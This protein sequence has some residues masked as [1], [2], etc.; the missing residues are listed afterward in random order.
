MPKGILKDIKRPP[1]FWQR[2]AGGAIS[3]R[4]LKGGPPPLTPEA[5]N[6]YYGALVGKAPQVALARVAQALLWAD[7][8]ARQFHSH[9]AAWYSWRWTFSPTM[10]GVCSML[11]HST[12][13]A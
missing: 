6:Y 2:L 7:I 10:S 1:T 3:A 4:K 5:V 11:P 9:C 13:M 8:K 12:T